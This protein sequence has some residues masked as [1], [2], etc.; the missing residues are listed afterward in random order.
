MQ[1][2]P[3]QLNLFTQRPVVPVEYGRDEPLDVRYQKWITVNPHV[4]DAFCAL[5]EQLRGAG[6]RH[7]GA[8]AVVERLRWEY[9]IQ[10]TGGEFKMDNNYTSRIVRDAIARRPELAGFFEMRMLRS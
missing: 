2:V 4:I 8:K 7:F 9:A 5:A 6:L 10:T 3:L 1:D